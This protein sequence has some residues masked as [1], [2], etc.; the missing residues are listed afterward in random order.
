MLRSFN[1]KKGNLPASIQGIVVKKVK[2]IHELK[3][4]NN[5]CAEMIIV[6]ILAVPS[7][8]T[9]LITEARQKSIREEI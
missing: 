9:T 6:A 3:N 1:I 7:Q 8:Y 5:C 4:N 2:L